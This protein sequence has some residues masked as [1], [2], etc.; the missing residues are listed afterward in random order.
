MHGIIFLAYQL[1]QH[2]IQNDARDA[3]EQADLDERKSTEIPQKKISRTPFRRA[4][5]TPQSTCARVEARS[6]TDPRTPTSQSSSDR[7]RRKSV[8][9]DATAITF[10]DRIGA[11]RKG[12]LPPPESRFANVARCIRTVTERHKKTTVATATAV[13]KT[14]H[15]RR[16]VVV[17]FHDL[18]VLVGTQQFVEFATVADL[19][20]KDPALAEGVFVDGF[21][22]VVELFVDLHDFARHRR[23]D[24]GGGLDRLDH[25][26]TLACLHLATDFRQL[27]IDQVAELTLGVVGNTHAYQ[28]VVFDTGPF[29]G[30]EKFQIAGDLAHVG[31]LGKRLWGP[32]GTVTTDCSDSRCMTTPSLSG[33]SSGPPARWIPAARSGVRSAGLCMNVRCQAA[34]CRHERKDISRCG[35]APRGR[36]CP[37]APRP[38]HRWGCGQ[39]RPPC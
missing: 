6:D 19:D 39:R 26:S 7:I 4:V 3:A 16:S 1:D 24:V 2:A 30:L 20:G 17:V 34:A 25:R 35:P 28:A 12:S 8:H 33:L 37:R 11:T 36:G 32:I 10:F 15:R 18:G 21:G 5:S 13:R 31:L 14:W 22:G 23:I 9:V 29:V 38:V 27:D